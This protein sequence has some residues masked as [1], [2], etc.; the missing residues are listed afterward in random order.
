VLSASSSVARP[1]CVRLITIAVALA[2]LALPSSVA[3]QLI[4]GPGPG[5][6]PEVHVIDEVS[7]RSLM[8]YAPTFLGGVNV[9]L[10][11]VNGDGTVDIIT[12]A[13]QGGGPHVRVFNGTDLSPLASFFAYSTS[14]T[15]GVY[16]AAGRTCR[17]STG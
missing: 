14:F 15:G 3:A 17:C 2:V 6:T 11:D 13:G 4:V 12:G 7:T 9:T 1:S 16:V 5:G 10:G 8:V